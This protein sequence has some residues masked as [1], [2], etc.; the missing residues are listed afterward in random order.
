M[1]THAKI[2][3]RTI[4]LSQRLEAG[5]TPEELLKEYSQKWN[6]SERTIYRLLAF[7]YD[8]VA[9][10][11]LNPEQ[12]LNIVRSEAIAEVFENNLLS[13]LE[14]EAKLCRLAERED[15]PARERIH[16]ILGILRVR[17]Q[18]NRLIEK[19]HERLEKEKPKV[20]ELGCRN[21]TEKK[22][23]EDIVSS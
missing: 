21:L 1:S 13:S 5:A 16:A 23:L 7:A 17:G 8:M 6:C 20:F 4:E 12:V 9:G 19:Q 3:S 22:M 18:Q 15:L 14:L 11:I 2:K 10:K